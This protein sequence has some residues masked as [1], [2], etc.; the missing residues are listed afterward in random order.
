MEDQTIKIRVRLSQFY[1]LSMALRDRDTN[2][3]RNIALAAGFVNK[4]MLKGSIKL[5]RTTKLIDSYQRVNIA[6]LR[7]HTHPNPMSDGEASRLNELNFALYRGRK[8]SIKK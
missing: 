2:A 8:F 1:P 3:R 4:G 6:V 7:V 5:V